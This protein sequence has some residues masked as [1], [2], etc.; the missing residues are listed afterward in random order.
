MTL[1][2][3]PMP[4]PGQTNYSAI[5]A[6][7][8]SAIE[9]AI[10]SLLAQVSAVGGEAAQL[11]TDV[12]DRDG[13]VGARSY[14]LDTDAYEGGAS[15]SIGHRPAADLAH[16]D[17]DLSIAWGT[18]AGVKKR[19]T[20]DGDA[21]L[22]AAGIVSGLPK[23]IWVGIPSDGTPQLYEDD[24]TPNVL[25]AY[26]MCWD[27]F[28]F[29]EFTRIAPILPGYDLM[30]DLANFQREYKVDDLE[31]DFLEDVE[32][33][34]ALIT[35]G[36][37]ADNEIGVKGAREILGFFIDFPGDQEDGLWAPNGEDNKLVL[38]ITLEGDP[39]SYDEDAESEEIEIDASQAENFFQI[40]LHPDVG[41]S[42]FIFDHVRFKL[43]LVSIGADVVSARRF[44][45]GYYWRPLFGA[46]LPVDSE[47][48]NLI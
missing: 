5:F 35:P 48:V 42:R 44:T 24:V 27:G 19:V 34:S 21:V 37:A 3:L 23:T 10:N 47:K 14:V 39:W 11:I 22:N 36:D 1:T 46:Q 6:S 45:W 33:Q 8:F 40:P 4:T 29:T 18:F 31:T 25:Y 2:L 13:L 43:E 15:I 28:Q 41:V 20:L 17:V 26:S 12:F 30:R 32:A 38:K 7:N 16:G 9:A